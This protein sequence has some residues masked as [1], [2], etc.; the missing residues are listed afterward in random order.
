[1]TIVAE[2]LNINLLV[3]SKH[4]GLGHEQL[5]VH[6]LLKFILEPGIHSQTCGSSIW[7]TLSLSPKL[8]L[9]PFGKGKVPEISSASDGLLRTRYLLIILIFIT[10][11]NKIIL[12]LY[13]GIIFWVYIVSIL[14]RVILFL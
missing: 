6:S 1:M 5:M 9:G 12:N 7:M 11:I 8:C 14:L 13:L 4:L 3:W 2:T 10:S